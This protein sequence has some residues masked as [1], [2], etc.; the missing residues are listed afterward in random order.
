MEVKK[1]KELKELKNNLRMG[2]VNGVSI[3]EMS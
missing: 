3:G 2:G 1:R